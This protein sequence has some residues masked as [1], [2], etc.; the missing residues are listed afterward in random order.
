[1]ITDRATARVLGLVV[2]LVSLI[3]VASCFIFSRPETRDSPRFPVI[4]L[5]SS[6]PMFAASALLFLKASRM[7]ED[8]VDDDEPTR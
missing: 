6:L 3:I 1:M 8:G 4:V 7:K 5:V 2:L